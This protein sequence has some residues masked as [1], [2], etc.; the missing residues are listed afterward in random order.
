MQRPVFIM[1]EATAAIDPATDNQIQSTIKSVFKDSTV[2]TIAHRLNTIIDYDK[3]L[4][5][6]NG[7]LA[8][9][10]TPQNL[11]QTPGI[12]REMCLNADLV[13]K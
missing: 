13:K 7:Q 9:F 12:F 2:I 6:Q 5:L 1:D 11:I 3:I 10:N 4:T 8:Q